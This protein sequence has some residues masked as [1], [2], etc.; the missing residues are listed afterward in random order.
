MN[1]KKSNIV[2][3]TVFLMAIS[4]VLLYAGFSVLASIHSFR[5]VLHPIVEPPSPLAGIVL[6]VA[7]IGL[8]ILGVV[9]P[10]LVRRRS[11]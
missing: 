2:C 9:F 4:L 1:L 8:A 5:E 7:G 6:I 11:T 3:F 10:F